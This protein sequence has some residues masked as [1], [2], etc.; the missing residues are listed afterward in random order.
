MNGS[1]S[2]T[3]INAKRAFSNNLFLLKIAYKEAP[4]YTFFEL[5]RNAQH[6]IIVFIEHVYM[7]GFIIDCIQFQRPF[8]YVFWFITGVFL[9]V[10]TWGNLWNNYMDAKVK[11][12]ALEKIYRAIRRQLYEKSVEMDLKNYDDPAFYDEFVWAMGEAA[13]RVLPV[14]QTFSQLFGA[15]A[16]IVVLS[17]YVLTQDLFGLL[18]TVFSV[19]V[20]LLVSGKYNRLR[21]GMLEKLKPL[22]RKRDYIS[23]V[24]YLPEYAKELRMGNIKPKLYQEFEQAAVEMKEIS[25]RETKKLTVYALIRDYFCNNFLYDGVYLLYL[26]YKT[27]CHSAFGYGTMVTLYNSCGRLKNSAQNLARVFPMFAEHGRYIEKIRRFLETQS[28]IAEQENAMSAG[29]DFESLELKNVS[30]SYQDQTPVLQNLNLTIKKGER[31]ALVGYNGAGKTTLVK[32]MM[33]LYDVTEGQIL[34]NGTDIRELK[35]SD[36]RAEF[37]ALFQ[38][39]QLFAAS[40]GENITMDTVTPER[41]QAEKV[42]H[43]SGFFAKFQ[44]LQAG[45]ETPVTREFEE[46]GVLFSG[47]ESQK[48]GISRALYPDSSVIILDEPSSALDPLSEYNLNHT[49]MTLDRDKTVIFISHRLSTTRLADRICMLENGRIVEEGT[50]E[51]LMALH[52]KYAEMFTLQMGKYR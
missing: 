37:S 34:W 19:A 15:I 26:L 23:R 41:E 24:F 28:Q 5:Q 50:H 13:Q 35:L 17:A 36:Y 1:R 14:L 49:M 44:T 22:E 43:K 46:N 30:F 9:L 16:G 7:I 39:Y 20:I 52:G 8:A 47:G 11:P 32:L 27:I 31:V 10:V 12:K 6:Q 48:I 33:R 3:T 29:A 21:M 25:D 42:I 40:L 4:F 45:F 51:Q 2:D 38:D 18:L